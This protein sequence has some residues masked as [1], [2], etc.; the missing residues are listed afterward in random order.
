MLQTLLRPVFRKK[1]AVLHR[2]LPYFRQ[3]PILIIHKYFFTNTEPARCTAVKCLFEVVK[4]VLARTHAA[5]KMECPAAI[6]RSP[7]GCL[8]KQ[9]ICGRQVLVFPQG[10]GKMVTQPSIGCIYYTCC[11]WTAELPSFRFPAGIPEPGAHKS[12]AL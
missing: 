5:A 2:F 9:Q 1:S 11:Q 4:A 12:V 10:T 8:I 7:Q 3:Y 6:G